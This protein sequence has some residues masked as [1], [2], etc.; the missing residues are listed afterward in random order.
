MFMYH[1]ESYPSGLGYSELIQRQFEN[2]AFF[3]TDPLFWFCEDTSP[4]YFCWAVHDFKIKKYLHLMCFGPI[5]GIIDFK[6]HGR[7]V[8]LEE[9]FL[10]DGVA[11]CLNEEVSCV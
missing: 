3:P 7:L 10:F 4:H 6:A 11:L 9:D 2:M 1:I 5:K 8:V